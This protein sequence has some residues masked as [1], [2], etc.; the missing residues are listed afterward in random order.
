M[1]SNGRTN[2]WYPNN[3]EGN[4]NGARNVSYVTTEP[5]AGL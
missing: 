3:F 2:F 1:R 4:V 5:N